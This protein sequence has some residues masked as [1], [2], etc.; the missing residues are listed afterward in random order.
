VVTSANDYAARNFGHVSMPPHALRYE[1]AGEFVDAVRALWDSW[2]DGA[3][4]R[5]TGVYFD[6]Q[7]MH[8]VHHHGKFF[9]L[10]GALPSKNAL[11]RLALF[12]S[13]LSEIGSSSGSPDKS[14]SRSV[15]SR[16]RPTSGC[17]ISWRRCWDQVAYGLLG[18]C[19][20]AHILSDRP[21]QCCVTLSAFVQSKLR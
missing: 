15:P 6:S 1:R 18:R 14:I 7:G 10:D 20:S 19:W 16:N 8:V 2:A 11:W 12:G 5:E 3:F 9:K 21:A 17:I 13:W 4:I